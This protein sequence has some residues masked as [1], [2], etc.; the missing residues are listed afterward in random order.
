MA[1]TS[2]KHFVIILV[3]GFIF[4]ILLLGY[5]V[6]STFAIT[7]FA[8]LAPVHSNQQLTIIHGNNDPLPTETCSI[9]TASDHCGNQKYG[10][11]LHPADQND[12]LV[13][14]PFPGKV[15]WIGGECLGIRTLDNLNLSVCHFQQYYVSLYDYVNRGDVLGVR[16][17][18]S[19]HL[20]LDDRYAN[21]TTKPP[22]P[23]NGLHTLKSISFEPGPTTCETNIMAK[24]STLRILQNL[25]ILLEGLKI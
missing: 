9:G 3:S 4:M 11:D 17:S 22:I 14:A 19:I 10:F 23:F 18:S 13:L 25:A 7:D 15:N 6:K 20:S 24:Q 21:T 16:K 2:S 5:S 1:K 8:L 12:L